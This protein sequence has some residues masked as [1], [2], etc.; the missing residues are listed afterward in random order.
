MAKHPITVNGMILEEFL[1]DTEIVKDFVDRERLVK[2]NTTVISEYHKPRLRYSIQKEKNGKV[3]KLNIREVNMAQYEQR[4]TSALERKEYKKALINVLLCNEKDKFLGNGDVARIFKA[5]IKKNNLKNTAKNLTSMVK[6]HIS[7][8]M[9]SELKQHVDYE[10]Y[11]Y[12]ESYRFKPESR[13]VL[14]WQK[15]MDLSKVKNG[16]TFTAK[17][18]NKPGP[19]PKKDKISVAT[20]KIEVQQQKPIKQNHENK[21]EDRI[22]I[23]VE[24]AVSALK[25]AESIIKIENL[26]ITINIEK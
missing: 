15:C 12:P 19:V 6:W 2:E 8:V 17:G 18:N 16:K 26:N 11:S 21:T 5:H 3:R 23:A 22:F 25:G 9:E 20:P 24:K 7:K 1:K 10:F 4:L 14:L 13:E